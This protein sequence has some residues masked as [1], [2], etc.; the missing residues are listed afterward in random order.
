MGHVMPKV[1]VLMVEVFRL[2]EGADTDDVAK[3]MAAGLEY[4]M[5]QFPVLTGTLQINV[6]SGEMWVE[7]KRDSTVSLHIKRMLGPD[8]F[9]SFDELAAKDVSL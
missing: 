3:S 7:K 1:Y 4:A 9:P 6:E 2:P 8:E 5:S